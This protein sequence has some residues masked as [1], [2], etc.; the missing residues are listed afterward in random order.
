MNTIMKVTACLFL[1]TSF[2]FADIINIPTD[3]D[4]IQGG[5][6]LANPG[7]TVLVQPGTYVEIINF[8]GKNIVVGSLTLTTGDTSHISQTIIDGGDEGGHI[9]IVTFENGEDSTSIFCGF[10][11]TGA[12][13]SERGIDVKDSSPFLSYLH[14]IGNHSYRNGAG[15]YFYNSNSKILNIKNKSNNTGNPEGVPKGGGIYSDSS[16]LNLFN[17]DIANN[18]GSKGGGIYCKNSQ[19]NITNGYIKNNYARG[20]GYLPSP[21]QGAGIYLENSI[22]NFSNVNIKKNFSAETGGGIFI[23]SSS[24][25]HFNSTNLCN[26][27]NNY[28]E[29][30]GV[31]ADLYSFSDSIISVIVDTF[32]VL[33]PDSSHAYPINKFTFDILNDTTGIAA[34]IE[35]EILT[36]LLFNLKQNYPNPF[37]PSTTIKYTL[38]KSE[39]IKIEVFNLLG[40]KIETLINK[41]MPAGSHEVEFTAKDLPSGVYLYRIET[42]EFQEVRKMILMK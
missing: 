14:V 11:V 2:P 35:N 16:N 33:N 24:Q 40:Q 12:I 31:G 38:L 8:N 39:K 42:G 32:T 27:Y 37:N 34:E 29:F 26:I 19:L 21:G 22:A 10:T 1:L 20:D 6:N 13:T 9:G 23:D 36:P 4:S 30:G 18:S 41:L 5:I 15:M 3:I 17:V 25:V 7:D 28:L